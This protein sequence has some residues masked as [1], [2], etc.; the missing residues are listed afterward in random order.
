MSVSMYIKHNEHAHHVIHIQHGVTTEKLAHL[1]LSDFGHNEEP[2]VRN[3]KNRSCTELLSVKMISN[4]D[5][6]VAAILA[7]ILLL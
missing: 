4:P 7:Y 1:N 2:I 6:C 3:R 5:H